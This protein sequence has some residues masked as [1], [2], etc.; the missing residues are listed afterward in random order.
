GVGGMFDMDPVYGLLIPFAFA[1]G[2]GQA[3]TY[4]TIM[5]QEYG[6]MNA[7]SVGI[8][9]AAVGFLVF[10]LV[11]VPL[12]RYGI[13][14]GLAKNV[15][16]SEINGFVQKGYYE[17]DEKRE[18]LGNETMFSGNMDT[19]TFHF[20]VIGLCFVMALGM[21]RLVSLIPGIGATFGG[22]LFIYGM[23]AGYIV[24]YMMKKLNIDY[25]IDNTFQ[26]KITGWSTDY[27]IVASFMAVPFSVIGDWMIPIIIEVAVI[28][29]LSIAICI[30]FGQRFGGDNDF[31]RTIGLYGTVTGTVPSGIALVRIIDPALRTS[32]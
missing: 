15:K 29:L 19:M 27:L 32:T 28:T 16:K 8:T 6:L 13:K 11:G 24:K 12:A 5:E 21:A 31:E 18:S 4:G 30:Y 9:F 17:K 26:T 22:M 20:S 25:M 23:L 14:K 7:A 1:Q 2:P 3:A 10:F